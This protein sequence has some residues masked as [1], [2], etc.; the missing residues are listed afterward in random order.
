M[1]ASRCQCSIPVPFIILSPC[2][3]LLLKDIHFSGSNQLFSAHWI[4]ITC[5]LRSLWLTNW[6]FFGNFSWSARNDLILPPIVILRY[7]VYHSLNPFFK[8]SIIL[9]RIGPLLIIQC[10][11]IYRTEPINDHRDRQ[12]RTT[13]HLKS[14]FQVT[15]LLGA[16]FLALQKRRLFLLSLQKLPR[17]L[18]N[19]RFKQPFSLDL[20]L[21]LPLSQVIVFQVV[22]PPV[23]LPEFGLV[24]RI[25]GI[26]SVVSELAVYVVLLYIILLPP[27]PLHLGL[28]PLLV[29]L[30][31]PLLVS[32]LFNGVACFWVHG[33]A[34]RLGAVHHR[35]WA[36]FNCL[37]FWILVLV[38]AN[39]WFWEE[40]WFERLL[41]ADA[42]VLGVVIKEYIINEMLILVKPF[43][44][45]LKS[46]LNLPP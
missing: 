31:Q 33:D 36:W 30:R 21:K 15:L 22:I 4:E 43:L 45:L 11:F 1:A 3:N 26:D 35:V 41:D 39:G 7:F 6:L 12:S 10:L 5:S 2:K 34:D 27:L 25:I 42:V 29:S 28:P 40:F 24:P 16:T 9:Q 20:L 8:N 44:K 37:G 38:G 17:L 13:W 18:W 32:H 19:L 14:P 23:L 46:T